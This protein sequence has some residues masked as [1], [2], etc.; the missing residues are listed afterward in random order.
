MSIEQAN[1]MGFV[2]NAPMSQQ[3]TERRYKK[4]LLRHFSPE[5]LGR[6]HY[7]I[8]GANMT[9]E[10]AIEIAKL[11]IQKWSKKAALALDNKVTITTDSGAIAR[12]LVGNYDVTK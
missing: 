2:Q 7:T 3:E 1:Q 10:T 11:L 6:I 9:E 12:A 5:F 4:T 8:R